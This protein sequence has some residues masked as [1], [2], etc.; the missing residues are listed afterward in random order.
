MA[1]IIAPSDMMDGRVAAIRSSLDAHGFS[2]VS[3]L[4]YTAKY[5]SGLYGPF[6]EAL[7]SAPKEAGEKPVPPHKKSYQM[8]PA[9]RCLATTDR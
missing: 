2:D 7:N 3:I 5:A 8:D 4:S 1:D 9:N 6:R